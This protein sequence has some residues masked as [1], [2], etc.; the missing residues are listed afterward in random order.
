METS[1]SFNDQNKK[2]TTTGVNNDG[3]VRTAAVDI[4]G[5]DIKLVIADR[6]PDGSLDAIVPLR[7]W[8]TGLRR[9][10]TDAGQLIPWEYDR[11]IGALGE[12]GNVL[13]KHSV[14][15]VR[16]VSCSAGRMMSKQALDTLSGEV[17]RSL[18]TG[19][20][21]DVSA[22]YSA[23]NADSGTNGDNVPASAGAYPALHV[24]PGSL[25]GELGFIGATSKLPAGS[26]VTTVDVGGGSTE[27][28]IGTTGEAPSFTVSIP[29]GGNAL[30]AL[31]PLQTDP[32]VLYEIAVNA[33]GN[34]LSDAV[35]EIE[36]INA[37]GERIGCVALGGA[38]TVMGAFA[39]DMETTDPFRV[40]GLTFLTQEIGAS[41]RKLSLMTDAGRLATKC[42]L[43]GRE[44][45]IHH[46]GL[47]LDAVLRILGFDEVRIS[48]RGLVDALLL[49]DEW[50]KVLSA[51]RVSA[52]YDK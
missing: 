27:V 44:V 23:D 24:V 15:E 32:D 11:T 10:I 52:D 50:S 3:T 51:D 5:N 46:S 29:I 40:D 49:D 8:P 4:G 17:R 18:A 9:A 16:V 48:A 20:G 22:S 42:V 36:H 34:G 30:R 14:D 25:E 12:I 35:S 45:A 21:N 2:P 47:V 38:A 43:P 7:D 33:I 19:T 31:A 6:R 26:F 28:S 41:A 1:D 39:S 13:R 37:G